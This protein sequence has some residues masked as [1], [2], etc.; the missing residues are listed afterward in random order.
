MV[1]SRPPRANFF[2]VCSCVPTTRF[3]YSLSVRAGRH[4]VWGSLFTR[5]RVMSWYVVI[6]GYGMLL[7]VLGVASLVSTL[8]CWPKE[9]Q[10]LPDQVLLEWTC[11]GSVQVISWQSWQSWQCSH[12][13]LMQRVRI[14]LGIQ[15]NS[16][17]IGCCGGVLVIPA[18]FTWYGIRMHTES[19]WEVYV[20]WRCPGKLQYFSCT[21]CVDSH[22][23]AASCFYRRPKW[24]SD[25]VIAAVMPM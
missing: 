5:G 13:F 22:V 11:C 21:G 6:Y 10:F 2:H 25:T 12:Q 3:L 7:D 18:L 15:W 23:L 16:C 4:K 24:L 17:C 14:F 9:M 1:N 8:S 19:F 20:T